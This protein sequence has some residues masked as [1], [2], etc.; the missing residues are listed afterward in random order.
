MK[1]LFYIGIA[2]TTLC[3]YSCKGTK[4]LNTGKK[5]NAEKSSQVSNTDIKT[6]EAQVGEQ[7]A[8]Q[9]K[10]Q[11]GA[12]NF[13]D[14]LRNGPIY[15]SLDRLDYTDELY[16]DIPEVFKTVFPCAMYFKHTVFTLPP[17]YAICAYFE[18]E[19]YGLSGDFNIL[20]EKT[21]RNT[22]DAPFE[23]RVLALIYV[24]ERM[25]IKSVEVKSIQEGLRKMEPYLQFP[26]FNYEIDANVN[27]E[28]TTY[29]L[30]FKENKVHCLVKLVNNR[31]ST[32][33]MPELY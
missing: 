20:Y 9:Q 25:Q 23:M 17:T 31:Y 4:N 16:N 26:D 21:H 6:S 11:P 7:S 1:T 24:I 12:A 22:T 13:L 32:A 2:F 29:Y 15:Y 30:L 8:S 27:N 3:I 18:N 19:K 33:I 5:T 14:S 28:A 10:S